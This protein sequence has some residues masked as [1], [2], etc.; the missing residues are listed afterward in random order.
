[1]LTPCL[2][3]FLPTVY[4]VLSAVKT[5][6]RLGRVW[7]RSQGPPDHAAQRRTVRFQTSK[8]LNESPPVIP[9]KAVIHE[10]FLDSGLKL[11]GM[12]LWVIS[13]PSHASCTGPTLSFYCTPEAAPGALPGRRSRR[14]DQQWRAASWR[15]YQFRAGVPMCKLDLASCFTSAGWLPA[16]GD[17]AAGRGHRGC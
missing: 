15:R 7:S 13:C 17:A 3:P 4:A 16:A 1:M 6:L 8:V 5:R 9:A 2:F 10:A 11:A 14:T 12:T